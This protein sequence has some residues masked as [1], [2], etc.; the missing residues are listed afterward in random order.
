[1]ALRVLR[2]V[3]SLGGQPERDALARLRTSTSQEGGRMPASKVDIRARQSPIREGYR[4]NPQSALITLEVESATSDLSDPLHC[5][6]TPRATP[7]VRWQS[8]A[9]PAVGGTGDVPCSGDLLMG[10]LAA[11]QEVTLRMVAAAMNVELETLEVEVSGQ[12][13]LRGTLAMSREVPVGVTDIRCT[14]R[15]KVKD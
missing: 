7:A 15:V 1:M 11:C 8:G 13:D 10:A 3:H 14:T 12:A 2:V 9:H 5:A 4:Q 6:V